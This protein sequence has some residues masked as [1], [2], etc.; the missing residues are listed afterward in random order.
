MSELQCLYCFKTYKQKYNFNRHVS[1][2]KFLKGSEKEQQNN[3][4]LESEKIP[5]AFEMFQL[6]KELSMENENLKKRVAKMETKDST[7]KKINFTEWLQIQKPCITFEKW[8]VEELYPNIGDFLEIV[9]QKNLYD[10]I[11]KM[12][13]QYFSTC[14]NVLLPICCY[15]K[16]KINNV[17]IYDLFDGN[18]CWQQVSNT[19]LDKYFSHL[20]D[21]FIVV[22]TQVWYKDNKELI[23]STEKYKELYIENYKKVLGGTEK[24][25]VLYGKIRTLFCNHVKKTTKVTNMD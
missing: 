11:E 14:R 4:E 8:F 21:Q 1:I 18:N 19:I 16:N 24:K 9:F 7:T 15:Q 17:Y 22:F 3:I 5:N 25:D 13:K 2:C 6:I 10:G 12:L 23:E 20:C